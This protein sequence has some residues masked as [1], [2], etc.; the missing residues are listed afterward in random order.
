M[1]GVVVKHIYNLFAYKQMEMQTEGNDEE[2]LEIENQLKMKHGEIKLSRF[3][4]GFELTGFVAFLTWTNWTWMCL[5]SLLGLLS[6][7]LITITTDPIFQYIPRRYHRD[8]D[9][10]D[11][12][13]LLREDH[14]DPFSIFV[15]TA[16][17]RARY[18]VWSNF[19]SSPIDTF[20]VL[21]QTFGR[22]HR[23]RQDRHF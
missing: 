18:K 20:V 19:N 6:I 10:D 16:V 13:R 17:S 15:I 22:A 4:L 21:M 23:H 8:H 5:C 1:L 3:G 9:T 14:W 2:E 12:V 11:L 7:A